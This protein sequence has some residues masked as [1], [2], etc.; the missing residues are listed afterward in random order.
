MYLLDFDVIKLIGKATV[1]VARCVN[2]VTTGSLFKDFTDVFK[3]ELG[4]LRGTEAKIIVDPIAP[5]AL[6]EKVEASLSTQVSAGEF[7]VS[8]LYPLF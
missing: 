8:G 7:K 6:K 3:D 5:F 1:P 2:L 4:L